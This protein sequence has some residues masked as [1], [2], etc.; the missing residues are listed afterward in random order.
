MS[1]AISTENINET[2]A[3]T[4]PLLLSTEV[5]QQSSDIEAVTISGARPSNSEV[6]FFHE[7]PYKDRLRFFRYVFLFHS[8]RFALLG[9]VSLFTPRLDWEA[10]PYR[11]NDAIDLQLQSMMQ[12]TMRMI[13]VFVCSVIANLFIVS[14]KKQ[15]P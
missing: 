6:P 10:S 2:Q 12:S 7:A 5:K 11:A 4:S 3:L 1:G 15:W 8:L 13:A 14:R 9:Y